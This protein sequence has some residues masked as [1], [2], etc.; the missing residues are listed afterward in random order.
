MSKDKSNSFGH[1]VP[2]GPDERRLPQKC[3]GCGKPVSKTIQDLGYCK[4]CIEQARKESIPKKIE[5]EGGD[6][7]GISNNGNKTL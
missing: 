5:N 2:Y 3:K 4:A 1:F 7:N 6:E